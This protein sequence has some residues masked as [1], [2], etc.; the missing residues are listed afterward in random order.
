MQPKPNKIDQMHLSCGICSQTSN[1]TIQNDSE[2]WRPD[3]PGWDN[4]VGIYSVGNF[5][6]EILGRKCWV[7]IFGWYIVCWWEILSGKFWEGNIGWEFLGDILFV[8]G[9]F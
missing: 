2:S 3:G 7:G 4:F 9:K 5:G 1:Q 8:G 6:W